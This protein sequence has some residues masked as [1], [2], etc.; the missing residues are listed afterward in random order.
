MKNIQLIMLGILVIACSWL[1]TLIYWTYKLYV[2]KQCYDS[3][4][5]QNYCEQYKDF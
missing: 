1:A 5:E 4:F 2:F 3:N